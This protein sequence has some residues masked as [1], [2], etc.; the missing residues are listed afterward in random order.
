MRLFK[1]HEGGAVNKGAL[2]I[3][4]VIL[5]AIAVILVLLIR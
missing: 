2:V 4:L 3:A 5:G 1:T